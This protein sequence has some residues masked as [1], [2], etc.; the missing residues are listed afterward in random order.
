MRKKKKASR[1]RDGVRVIVLGSYLICQHG[2]DTSPGD[3]SNFHPIGM[4]HWLNSILKQSRVGQR[5]QPFERA[6][7]IIVGL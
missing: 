4:K 7:L 1:Q 5:D 6:S 2:K 3:M